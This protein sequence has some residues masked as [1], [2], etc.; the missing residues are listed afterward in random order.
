MEQD[1]Q[2]ILEALRQV[3]SAPVARRMLGEA[4]R[5]AP[6]GASAAEFAE[7]VI[8]SATPMLDSEERERL[9]A[10]LERAPAAGS[11][12]QSLTIRNSRDVRRARMLARSMAIDLSLGQLSILGLSAAV[13]E[14]AQRIVANGTTGTISLEPR[15]LPAPTVR[16]TTRI[17]SDTPM[18]LMEEVTR[19]SRE[20][21]EVWAS[22]RSADAFDVQLDA[23]G[24]VLVFELGTVNG[25][26]EG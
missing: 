7:F 1:D 24:L 4:R 6:A 19:P 26:D 22:L 21:D 3:A 2:A 8:D 18:E 16:V 10:A 11:T 12:V 17:N 13:S 15:K 14:L 9:R 25:R 23:D 5:R 20:G